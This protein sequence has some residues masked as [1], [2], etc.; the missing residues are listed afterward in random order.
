VV[1]L[2]A[3]MVQ[4]LTLAARMGLLLLLGEQELAVRIALVPVAMQKQIQAQ[5]V[6][7]ELPVEQAVLPPLEAAMEHGLRNLS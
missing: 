3:P 7:V 2:L 6:A 1:L 5:A 4:A